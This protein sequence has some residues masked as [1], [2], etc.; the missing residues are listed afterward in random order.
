TGNMKFMMNG[1]ITIGTMDGANIEIYDRVGSDAFF[2]FGLGV[3]EVVAYSKDG[4]YS[5]RAIYESNNNVR[6]IVDQMI[7]GFLEGVPRDLFMNIYKSLVDYNDEFFLLKDFDDYL[8]AQGRLND[9][10]KDKKRWNSMSVRNIA[11]SGHFSSDT[12]IGRYAEEI[13]DIRPSV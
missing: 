13:W 10:Y 9:A 1:A 12:T 6:R 11:M 2:R 7:N 3:D 8:A 4:S 5:S